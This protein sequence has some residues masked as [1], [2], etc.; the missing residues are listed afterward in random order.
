MAGNTFPRIRLFQNNGTT[1]VFEFALVTD[2]NDFQDPITFSEHLSLRGQ[3]S[4]VSEGSTAPWDL[5][6]T[7]ILQGADYEDLVAQMDSL[8]S[9][10]VTNTQYVLR[11]DLTISTTKVY[12]VKRLQSFDFPLDNRKKRVNFQTVNLILRSNS[13]A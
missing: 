1:L 11:V 13:W 4:I 9:T 2:I 10:I 12:K 7:F 6:L 5:N 8:L 3:G